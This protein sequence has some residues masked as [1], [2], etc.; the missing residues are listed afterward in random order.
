MNKLDAVAIGELL[1]D[2]TPAGVSGQGLPR[3][4]QNPGGAPANVMAGL[5]KLGKRTAFIGKVG[6][7]AFGR[8]LT[9]ELEK[10]GVD[11][12]GMVFTGEAG[13]TLA[14]VSL[15][16]SGDRSF[17]FYRNP[18]ADMLLQESEIDW[19]RI[20]EA[21]LFHFG[22]VSMTHEPSAS[23][24]LR[25][26]AFARREGKLV[27]FDPNLRPLLWPDLDRAKRLIL[28]GL[29]YSDVLKLSEEE[30][31]FLT[32]E[33]DL[34]A[35][36]RQLREQY[37]TPLIFVTLGPDGSFY[38]QGERTGR[39][40]GFAVNAVDTTGAGD[41]FFSGALFRLMESGK[42]PDE[43]TEAELDEVCRSGN[44]AGALTTTRK[45]AIP[46]LPSLEELDQLIRGS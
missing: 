1:I 23:A 45:G 36:T 2:F 18:G 29:T 6:E 44:A 39:V 11:T 14:F 31:H 42:R 3:Y 5:T 41:A 12:G 8:F 27:S 43:L 22:S 37:D 20:G 28:E 46:A 26:A 10:H 24:T 40:P 35:G 34:E 30:L 7:D 13:T 15:D 32:G 25:A 16:A 9:G 33:R 21:A 38:R 19:K 17:S 4:E